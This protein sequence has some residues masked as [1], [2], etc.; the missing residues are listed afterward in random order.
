[1]SRGCG[2]E[3]RFLMLSPG[4][5]R[6]VLGRHDFPTL[7]TLHRTVW[8]LK[9]CL[10]VNDPDEKSS[11]AFG[12]GEEASATPFPKRVKTSQV[13]EEAI[14]C[15]INSKPFTP[16]IS[17]YRTLLFPPPWL[18]LQQNRAGN[19]GRRQTRVRRRQGVAAP[20]KEADRLRAPD[21]LTP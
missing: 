8:L 9:S 2:Q 7:H 16:V 10:R 4:L 21:L 18:K 14:C 6:Q 19:K 13:R 17:P 11:L 5:C 20:F 1:M 12:P 15:H 3:P